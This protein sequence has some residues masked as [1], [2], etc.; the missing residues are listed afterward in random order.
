MIGRRRFLGT[1]LASGAAVVHPALHG[2]EPDA[3]PERRTGRLLAGLERVEGVRAVKMLQNSYAQY[4]QYGLWDAIG[5]LFADDGICQWDG[6]TVAGPRAIAAH[7]RR[8]IGG[9]ADGISPGALHTQLLMMPVITL[10]PGGQHAHGRWHEVRMLSGQTAWAASL[11]TVSYIRSG[12]RWKIARL[13]SH[14]IFA[15]SYD[16]GWRNVVEDLPVVPYLISPQSAGRPASEA[17]AAPRPVAD[18]AGV[19]GRL[20]RLAAE[21]AVC[22]LQNAYGYYLDRKMWDDIVDLFA[23]DGSM[24]I[25]GVGQFKGAVN[26]RRA[27]ERDGPAGLRHGELNDHP[28]I[29]MTVEVAPSGREAR[30]RG[31]DLGMVGINGAEAS[32]SLTTFDNRFVR[33]GDGVW[34][35]AEMRLYPELKADYD[36]GWATDARLDRPVPRTIAAFPL[37][38]AT[39]AAIAYPAGLQPVAGAFDSHADDGLARPP[40][41][42][43]AERML[44][45]AAAVN[46]IETISSAIGNYL[47][48][49]L[50]YELSRLFAAD[51]W[52]KSPSAGYYRGRDRIWQM[53]LTRNG[54]P[55]RP[56]TSLPLHL[57][58]QPVIHVAEDGLT[59]KLRTRLL[60]FNSSFAREGS[61]TAGM[62]EDRAVLEDGIWRLSVDDIEHI[63]RAPSY[64]KGWARIEEG[65]GER[66]SRPPDH[67]LAAMPPDRPITGARF[68]SFPDIAPLSFHYRN[69]VSG[70]AP[71]HLLPD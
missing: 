25:D 20:V 48:D 46:A 5:A 55:R 1:L 19:Q 13:V 42:D 45:R 29:N 4:L 31:L 67:L 56:R 32:W 33:R 23:A 53:Q 36:R 7:M 65:S 3:T 49:S 26:I 8:V 68:P 16:E 17:W 12:Q 54:P 59:A 61:M 47:N 6:V 62:Y 30:V 11:L 35:I 50:W 52:R 64:A 21:D 34:T 22:N 58:L 38:P 27:L 18:L 24:S 66:L 69:P 43:E 57:R 71:P 44:A 37:H 51:G 28:Q 39:G 60:Q 14:P 41:L 40:D 10:S 2:A 70:R 63:W 15:G 9:G